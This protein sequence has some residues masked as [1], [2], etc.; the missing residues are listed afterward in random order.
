[1]SRSRHTARRPW[2]ATVPKA[3]HPVA[4]AS[5]RSAVSGA[6]WDR[7]WLPHFAEGGADVA[8]MDT[9]GTASTTPWV[10]NPILILAF[11][12]SLSSRIRRRAGGGGLGPGPETCEGGADHG[13]LDGALR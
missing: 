7:P 8:P 4:A 3:H 2:L 12:I 5:H 6:A 9:S 11:R 1:M 10:I 13:Y